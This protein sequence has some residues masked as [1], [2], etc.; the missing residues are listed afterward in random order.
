VN[1]VEHGHQQFSPGEPLDGVDVES[2]QHTHSVVLLCE[3]RL[4]HVTL[5]P[6]AEL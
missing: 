1:Q 6:A 2:V 3:A 5:R 4:C